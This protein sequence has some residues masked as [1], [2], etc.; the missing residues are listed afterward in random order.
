MTKQELIKAIEK[1]TYGSDV[2]LELVLDDLR[3]IRE[4][5]TDCIVDTELT[6]EEDN[7]EDGEDL[8]EE[9]E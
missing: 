2:A 7:Y 8:E 9:Y 1:F 6:V 3:D 5:V 4:Y